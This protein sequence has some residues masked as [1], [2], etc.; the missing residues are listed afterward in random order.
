[1]RGNVEACRCGYTTVVHARGQQGCRWF[2]GYD[3]QTDPLGCTGPLE[4]DDGWNVDGEQYRVIILGEH[5]ATFTS[6]EDA[7]EFWAKHCCTS[8]RS[9]QRRAAG[10]GRGCCD[11]Q[12]WRREAQ[13]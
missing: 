6:P 5:V 7:A 2:G 8:C 12:T 1:M 9:P 11:V 13:P 3:W 4:T 10:Y